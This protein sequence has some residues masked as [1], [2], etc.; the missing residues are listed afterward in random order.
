MIWNASQRYG[1]EG[2]KCMRAPLREKYGLSKRDKRRL[3]EMA[4]SD[5]GGSELTIAIPLGNPFLLCERM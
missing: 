3:F 4:E 2:W 1:E 5:C